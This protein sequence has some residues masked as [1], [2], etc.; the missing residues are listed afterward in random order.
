MKTHPL[1]YER[2]K[3]GWSQEKVA[4]KVGT[5][6]RTVS[7]WERGLAIPYPYYREQLCA[8]F[9]KNAL[10]L[11]IVPA[12]DPH[13]EKNPP[14][15]E[16]EMPDLPHPAPT[17]KM[18]ATRIYDPTIPI[19]LGG[20]SDLIGR[21]DLLADLKKR[22]F[23]KKHPILTAFN[24]LPG[25]G[26]TALAVALAV[27]R[28]VQEEFR[29]GIVWV[30]LGTQPNVL[31]LLAHWGTLLG[32]SSASVGDVSSR[33]AWGMALRTAIGT[34]RM[35]LIIDDAWKAEDALA[36]QVGG[37]HC[38]Y[39]LTTRFP[40]VA[41]TFTMEGTLEIPQLAEEHGLALLARFAPEIM[42]LEPESVYRLVRSVGALPLALTLMGKYLASQALNKQPRRLHAAITNLHDAEQRLHLSM[43]TSFSTRS[44]SLPPG[45]PLS[46]QAT[47][48]VSDQSL[49]E[50]A[51]EALHALSILPAKPNSFSEEMALAVTG[52][53]AEVLDEI[54]DAG[55]LENQGPGRYALH[56]TI[57]D[58]AK[59]QRESP[60]TSMRLVDYG[61]AY[62][63]AHSADYELLSTEIP[64]ILAVLAAA[65]RIERHQ[66]LIS[67]VFAFAHFLYA[68]GLH[69]L[70]TELLE[71]A[72]TAA[73]SLGS[74][75]DIITIAR[76]LGELAWTL[77]ANIA[78]EK[79]LQEALALA[80]Q[81]GSKEQIAYL[82]AGM[83]ARMSSGDNH[84]AA[85]AYCQE[86]LVIARQL[87]NHELIIFLLSTLG[88]VVYEQKN[89]T[90]TKAICHEGL[91]LA[92]QHNKQEHICRFLAQLSWLEIMLGNYASADVA[93]QEGFAIARQ[94]QHT[95]TISLLLAGR[96]WLAS[97]LKNYVQAEEDTKQALELARNTNYD[98]LVNRMLISLGWLAEKREAYAEANAHYQEALLLVQHT[99]KPR[100]FCMLLFHLG[101]LRRKQGQLDAATSLLQ[102]ML[103][104]IPEGDQELLALAQ[105][106]LDLIADQ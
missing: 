93:L 19:M 52:V 68:R 27:D 55:L 77:S 2:E 6:V 44:P 90:R 105:G 53:K 38:A 85:E 97:K 43:P 81:Q 9:A 91:A 96:G 100:P 62:I 63:E 80:R 95:Y 98:E 83:S 65:R 92:H 99:K 11:G 73:K 30:G 15:I 17:E 12:S 66:D 37:P 21:D 18:Q 22:L 8:L 54:S 13:P 4:E 86:G 102:E 42:T 46:L 20:A 89:Y 24:G 72:Y 78:V 14:L 106:G 39:L 36:F 60:E 45:I 76:R 26:K 7:R 87:E 71:Q 33:E 94:I 101:M 48:A 58:Y 57:A 88:W 32:T 79:Y 74:M 75:Q 40:Q 56:Q 25:I 1:R 104:H 59:M 29:D 10:E 70:S 103:L 28:E 84:V 5:T 23:S 47:I 49:S 64:N 67:G 31:G 16:V 3:R 41:F 35:L 69:T 34:R 51:H 61:I 50:N 82:L